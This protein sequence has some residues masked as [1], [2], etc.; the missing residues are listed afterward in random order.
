MDHLNQLSILLQRLTADV[1]LRPCHISLYTVLCQTWLEN[2][3]KNPFNISRRRG[4]KLARISSLAT[5]HK[6]IRE[7]AGYKYIL[8]NPSFHP[9]RG[10]EVSLLEPLI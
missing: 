10:S 5:Y 1:H 4:M 9:V 3:C 6:V 8:Y 7:L 2:G